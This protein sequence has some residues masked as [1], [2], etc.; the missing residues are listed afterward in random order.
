MTQKKKARW[1]RE[2]K[3]LH[4]DREAVCRGERWRWSEANQWNSRSRGS[5]RKSGLSESWDGKEKNKQR[6]GKNRNSNE[7]DESYPNFRVARNEKRWEKKWETKEKGKREDEGQSELGEEGKRM[8]KEGIRRWT[9]EE[10]KGKREN[11]R[12]ERRERE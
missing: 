12:V 4:L 11:R 10:S 5:T 7:R 3:W 9:G 2:R 8:R 1:R 6:R